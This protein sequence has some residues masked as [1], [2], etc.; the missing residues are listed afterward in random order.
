MSDGSTEWEKDWHNR[1]MN[2]QSLT[3]SVRTGSDAESK[4]EEECHSF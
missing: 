1:R 3:N 2:E 4:E